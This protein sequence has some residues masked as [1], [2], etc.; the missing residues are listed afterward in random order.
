MKRKETLQQLEILG[1]NKIFVIMS[2]D[3]QSTESVL[4]ETAFIDYEDANIHA[5]QHEQENSYQ[6][7]TSIHEVVLK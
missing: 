2:H 5:G 6:F 3:T 1:L 7:Y 4:L